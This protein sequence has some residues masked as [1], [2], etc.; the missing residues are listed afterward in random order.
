MREL[1][2]SLL[3][4]L[5]VSKPDKPLDF[6]IDKLYNPLVKRIFILGPSGSER[7]EYA[8]RLKDRFNLTF[9]ETS[10]LLSKESKKDTADAK[11]IK[12]A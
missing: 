7:K 6:L 2:L 12:E 11:K 9:I 5:I 10:D 8:K 4:Q 3:K 1:F